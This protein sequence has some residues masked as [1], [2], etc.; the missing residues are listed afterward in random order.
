MVYGIYFFALGN[1]ANTQRMVAF[2]LI[3]LLFALLLYTHLDGVSA[4]SPCSTY[5][6]ANA[7]HVYNVTQQGTFD[8]TVYDVVRSQLPFGTPYRNNLYLFAKLEPRDYSSNFLFLDQNVNT[9]NE[10]DSSFHFTIRLIQSNIATNWVDTLDVSFNMINNVSCVPEEI[11]TS[12]V[13]TLSDSGTEGNTCNAVCGSAG[14]RYAEYMCSS[15]LGGNRKRGVIYYTATHVALVGINVTHTDPYANFTIAGVKLQDQ[16]DPVFVAPFTAGATCSTE[17]VSIPEQPTYANG[18]YCILCNAEDNDSIFAAYRG[19]RVTHHNSADGLPPRCGKNVRIDAIDPSYEPFVGIQIPLSKLGVN[20]TSRKTISNVTFMVENAYNSFYQIKS[21]VAILPSRCDV[22]RNVAVADLVDPIYYD[23]NYNLF[24]NDCENGIIQEPYLATYDVL[25]VIH[26]DDA[27]LALLFSSIAD[28]DEANAFFLF[29]MTVTVVDA[30]TGAV[31]DIVTFAPRECYAPNSTLDF[32]TATCACSNC[33]DI[34]SHS[35][36][37][38]PIGYYAITPYFDHGSTF[39]PALKKKRRSFEGFVGDVIDYNT[40]ADMD[41]LIN[42]RASQM[43]YTDNLNSELASLADIQQ[44]MDDENCGIFVRVKECTSTMQI[45][46]NAKVNARTT[47]SFDESP[48]SLISVVTSGKVYETVWPLTKNTVYSNSVERFTQLPPTTDV[49]QR[50]H[51]FLIKT[52]NTGGFYSTFN[53]TAGV[54]IAIPKNSPSDGIYFVTLTQIGLNPIFNNSYYCQTNSTKANG[55]MKVNTPSMNRAITDVMDPDPNRI[56]LFATPLCQPRVK[57]SLCPRDGWYFNT[58]YGVVLDYVGAAYS[59]PSLDLNYNYNVDYAQP[60]AIFPFLVDVFFD[61]SKLDL[62][63]VGWDGFNTNGNRQKQLD[64]VNDPANVFHMEVYVQQDYW[65]FENT[66][67]FE[68]MLLV[69]N[70]T[71][72]V[73]VYCTQNVTIVQ[74][75]MPILYGAGFLFDITNPTNTMPAYDHFISRVDF[76]ECLREFLL[77]PRFRDVDNL[78]TSGKL[79]ITQAFRKA[80]RDYEDNKEDAVDRVFLHGI[81][82]IGKNGSSDVYRPRNIGGGPASDGG[83]SC[84]PEPY[85][86]HCTCGI[87]PNALGFRVNENTL[88]EIV[89]DGGGGCPDVLRI[90]KKHNYAQRHIGISIPFSSIGVDP[91][92]NTL[93]TSQVDVFVQSIAST[94]V[95]AAYQSTCGDYDINRIMGVQNG[96]LDTIFS[97]SDVPSCGGNVFNTAYT[98]YSSQLISHKTNVGTTA[99]LILFEAFP[100]DHDTYILNLT[101][102]L[103]NGT[104]FNIPITDNCVPDDDSCSCRVCDG[105]DEGNP[106]L[107]WFISDVSLI[108]SFANPAYVEEKRRAAVPH[109]NSNIRAQIVDNRL[110]VVYKTDQYIHVFKPTDATL[111]NVSKTGGN[112]SVNEYMIRNSNC[113][114]MLSVDDCTGDLEVWLKPAR[115]FSVSSSVYDSRERFTFRCKLLVGHGNDGSTVFPMTKD[116]NIEVTT[117]DINPID[118]DYTSDYLDKETQKWFKVDMSSEID[119]SNYTL[120]EVYAFKIKYLRPDDMRQGLYINCDV[121]FSDEINHV[122]F[123]LFEGMDYCQL[124]S[125]GG[126]DKTNMTFFGNISDYTVATQSESATPLL[127]RKSPVERGGGPSAPKTVPPSFVITAAPECDEYKLCPEN[128]WNINTPYSYMADYVGQSYVIPPYVDG[129]Q[130]APDKPFTLDAKFKFDRPEFLEIVDLYR[131]S[132]ICWDSGPCSSQPILSVEIHINYPFHLVSSVTGSMIMLENTCFQDADNRG[133]SY[134]GSC[135]LGAYIG[136]HGQYNVYGQSNPF[137]SDVKTGDPLKYYHDHFIMRLTGLPDCLSIFEAFY[138]NVPLRSMGL[139]IQ[140]EFEGNNATM[141]PEYPTLLGHTLWSGVNFK[142]YNSTMEEHAFYRADRDC[143]PEPFSPPIECS[144]ACP[145]YL[146]NYGVMDE[147]HAI[148]GQLGNHPN[149]STVYEDVFFDDDN[150]TS[151]DVFD[152]LEAIEYAATQVFPELVSFVDKLRYEGNGLVMHFKIKTVDDPQ[153][154]HQIAIFSFD[155]SVLHN[156]ML[157]TSLIGRFPFSTQGVFVDSDPEGDETTRVFGSALG[158]IFTLD[159]RGKITMNAS[160]SIAN[161]RPVMGLLDVFYQD[162]HRDFIN[163]DADVTSE[164]VDIQRDQ[165]FIDSYLSP[166]AGSSLM[167]FDLQDVYESVLDFTNTNLYD[168]NIETKLPIVFTDGTYLRIGDGI[169]EE[170]IEGALPVVDSFYST[171][172]GN[173]NE[174][175]FFHPEFAYPYFHFSGDESSASAGTDYNE[176][177]WDKGTIIETIQIR[178]RIKATLFACSTTCSHNAT[179]RVKNHPDATLNSLVGDVLNPSSVDKNGIVNITGESPV[180]QFGDISSFRNANLSD[181]FTEEDDFRMGMAVFAN[182]LA[183]GFFISSVYNFDAD[184]CRNILRD[185][186][187]PISDIQGNFSIDLYNDLGMFMNMRDSNAAIQFYGVVCTTQLTTP[188]VPFP[189]PAVLQ[190][191]AIQL[192]M[193]GY[194][195]GNFALE[196]ALNPSRF[197]RTPGSSTLTYNNSYPETDAGHLD[198]I[199]KIDSSNFTTNIAQNGRFN[200][201]LLFNP[202]STG[203]PDLLTIG[204]YDPVNHTVEVRAGNLNIQNY[205]FQNSSFMGIIEK[206]DNMFDDEVVFR[207][208]ASESNSQSASTSESASAEG[209]SGSGSGVDGGSSSGNDETSSASASDSQ[210]ESDSAS[211]SD[212]VSESIKIHKSGGAAVVIKPVVIASVGGGILV[213]MIVAMIVCGIAGRDNRYAKIK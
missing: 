16:T 98:H 107:K 79:R 136:Y 51:R 103:N 150:I 213:F 72:C 151:F 38:D 6:F 193:F 41:Q 63:R 108:N 85:D 164:Y 111:F 24:G 140:L 201:T 129:E 18:E 28:Y 15:G 23:Y 68:S 88:A 45:Y 148:K 25:P 83:V 71:S 115:R 109:D 198:V 52:P 93:Y 87:A 132:Y 192:S 142:V 10:G 64:F 92:R 165:L 35:S 177:N 120:S 162:T 116:S 46:I 133:D 67:P 48:I 163:M 31:E 143:E 145:T 159:D 176:G 84:D 126:Y 9:I 26:D 19:S 7:P 49:T 196:Y 160:N 174:E 36:S 209:G 167:I 4:A 100:L 156:F 22:I 11:L 131:E 30:E 124:N 21:L 57:L 44:F 134:L 178:G 117:P 91:T 180:A 14:C 171:F 172:G 77:A 166:L 90:D 182:V 13:C 158:V 123:R 206:C 12:T 130:Y 2:P 86:Y 33:H 76:R 8:C 110:N 97:A 190:P 99:L 127:K 119:G 54:E 80:H 1:L 60:S 170:G 157:D 200:N 212:S 191:V 173:I 175:V 102:T 118:P 138:S 17:Q 203:L 56:H 189:L 20:S 137:L 95:T 149:S 61:L 141:L 101:V 211:Q 50:E 40:A 34:N 208:S 155:P 5:L 153:Y 74:E 70:G 32:K 128:G 202:N 58:P 43:L 168:D 194:T 183:P 65:R 154:Y 204:V 66:N 184:H 3:L 62:R 39:G 69:E 104:T 121:A 27:Y 135:D 205:G 139:S 122:F 112:M 53:I 82:F 75:M 37:E 161:F 181:V 78:F 55:L 73:P 125:Y 94:T 186:N 89:S 210:S 144:G 179:H 187:S 106:D 146:F 114:V 147:A 29:S 207:K 188:F 199:A 195:Q 113:G 42:E 59:F 47:F 96:F 185:I 197:T 152:C 169:D 105:S 81:N